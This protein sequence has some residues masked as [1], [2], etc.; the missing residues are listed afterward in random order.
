MDL[1]S[2]YLTGFLW[3]LSFFCVQ[4][5][6][7]PRMLQLV[8]KSLSEN[9]IVRCYLDVAI[10]SIVSYID[11]Q[12]DKTFSSTL[13]LYASIFLFYSS[14]LVSYNACTL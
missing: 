13:V 5:L 6:L 8:S 12:T 7:C 9:E 3:V 2:I 1:S 4:L 10:T 14:L 11:L